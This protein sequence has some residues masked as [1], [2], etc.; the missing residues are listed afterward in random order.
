MTKKYIESC[1]G[2]QMQ[3][4]PPYSSKT[5]EGKQLHAYAKEGNVPELPVHEVA[6]R[7]YRGLAMSECARGD[8]V[9]R[10]VRLAQTVRG[11]FRQAEIAAAWKALENKLPATLPLLSVTITVSSGFYVRTFAEDFGRTLGTGV[12]LYSLIRESYI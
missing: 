5:V 1:I 4:Y 9:A 6:L 8:I 3:K 12:C 11:D 7:G 10:A 2:S